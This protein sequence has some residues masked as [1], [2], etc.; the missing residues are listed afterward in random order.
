MRLPLLALALVS[1]RTSTTPP[2]AHRTTTAPVTIA[3]GQPLGWLGLGLATPESS[4]SW[5]PTSEEFSATAMTTDPLPRKV[6][7]IGAS[8]AAQVLA[9]APPDASERDCAGYGLVGPLLTGPRMP[10]GAVWVLPPTVTPSWAPAALELRTTRADPARRDYSAGPLTITLTRTNA[11]QGHL[12]ILRDGTLVHDLPFEQPETGMRNPP[13]IDVA[14]GG[15]GVPEPLAVW[16]V[17]PAGPFLVAV[18]MP[19]FVSLGI[20]MLL[21]EDRGARW[22]EGMGLHLEVCRF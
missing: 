18:M 21:V 5:I 9:V 14:Q 22:L 20:S 13:A 19:S 6:T 4:P 10:P 2:V 8:G 17:A 15:T 3:P 11:R 7:V 12:Q 16:S 1:C